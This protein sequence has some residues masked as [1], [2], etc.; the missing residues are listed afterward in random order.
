MASRWQSLQRDCFVASHSRKFTIENLQDIGIF[1]KWLINVLWQFA[2][3]T[4]IITGI[5]GQLIYMGCGPSWKVQAEVGNRW[6]KN[7]GAPGTTVD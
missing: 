6:F 2:K 7:S 1:F 4:L 3:Y 5:Q